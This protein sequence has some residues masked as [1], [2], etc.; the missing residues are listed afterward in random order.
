MS[1]RLKLSDPQGHSEAERVASALE[2]QDDQNRI[3]D[4]QAN[5]AALKKA[6]EE[7][8]RVVD[9]GPPSGN[10][11][12][13]ARKHP[14]FMAISTAPSINKTPIG[15]TMVPLP[16]PTVQDLTNSVNT[17][18]T[19]NFNGCPAYLLDHTTQPHC[20]GDEAGT[21][22]GIKSGTVSGEVKPV[23][24]SSTVR[25]EGKQVLRDG[26]P[27]TMNGGN[28][29]GVYVMTCP[30][31]SA[32]PKTAAQTSN[33]P[34]TSKA[35]HDWDTNNPLG[36]SAPKTISEKIAAQMQR[37]GLSG[38]SGLQRL[39]QSLQNQPKGPQLTPWD[40]AADSAKQLR[41]TNKLETALLGIF[42]GPGAAARL[43][44][45][46]EE[47]IAAANQVGAAAMGVG[48]SVAGTPSRQAISVAP[49]TTNPIQSVSRRINSVIKTPRA[50]DGIKVEGPR[51][52]NSKV[53]VAAL[54]LAHTAEIETVSTFKTVGVDRVTAD[55]YL[56]TAEGE[57]LIRELSSADPTA[58]ISKIY[59]RAVE[60]IGSGATAPKALSINS[61]L[62]KIVPEGQTVSPYSPF[63][64]TAA[65]LDAASE[66]GLSL[67]DYFGLP[68]KNE[69]PLYDIYQIS[70]TCPTT[71]FASK[72][73]PTSE[74]GGLV[75]RPGGATQ[76]VVPNRS[77]WSP[78]VLVG[79]IKN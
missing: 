76:Y 53:D 10:N 77:Q 3:Q 65:E 74:L 39:K 29:P 30:P 35:A 21:G 24:G 32:P 40:P 19:V 61:P 71:V 70:P 7:R 68:I 9:A 72:V 54:R 49:R 45:Q 41:A 2:R 17:A 22:K 60:Q 13:G 50:G 47:K 11:K 57:R 46:S 56:S 27:C 44:G 34:I 1:D 69:A 18:R 14:S 16:Y 20:K 62:V 28:N 48:L 58:D 79:K 63:F 5:I 23:K 52:D 75:L 51:S 8:K 78:P 36:L 25:V 15:P 12:I 66:V 4:L 67:A 59:A 26:D 6:L 73:A 37:D 64:T 42:G 31:S 55:R 43:A 38:T 33:P